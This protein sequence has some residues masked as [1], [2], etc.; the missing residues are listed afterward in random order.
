MGEWY[1]V[2]NVAEIPSP[3]LLVY[4]DRVEA[5]IRLMLEIVGGDLPRLRPH[6]KTHKMSEVIQLQ[7]EAGITKF[8]A[9]TIAEVEMTAAAGA[10]DILF[11]YQPVGP[12][13]ERLFKLRALYPEARISALVDDISAAEALSE[14]FKTAPLEV[15]IDVD[16]GMGRTGIAPVGA[17]ELA[18]KVVELPGLIFAGLHV[19]D[20]HLHQEDIEDRQAGFDTA[21]EG[22]ESL[23]ESF[24]GAGIEVPTV[25]GGGS[26]TYAIHASERGWECSPGTTLFWDAGY[27]SHFPDLEFLSAALLLT[28]VISKPGSNRLCLDLGHKAVAAEN[29]LENRVRFLNLPDAK[30]ISQSEEHLVIETADADKWAIGAEL[31]GMPWHI[32]PS[33]ALYEEAVIIRDGHAAE[34]GWR[35]AS[36]KRRL[37][38]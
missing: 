14:H 23:L 25:V 19:Y 10:P 38:V 35:V 28:R 8:K 27:G 15:F 2:D 33:V 13:M 11:A 26:P 1:E 20:G 4:P 12:N 22:V 31:Y 24:Q 17:T 21:M 29:P 18:R 30:P 9:A 16:C 5:N 34:V 37:T 3:S 6:V 36:R 32:C 7:V